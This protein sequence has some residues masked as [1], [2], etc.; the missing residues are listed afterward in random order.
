MPP[1]HHLRMRASR[2]LFWGLAVA[3]GLATA[4]AVTLVVVS[5]AGAGAL[6]WVLTGV[7]PLYA[8]A[9]FT[10]WRRPDHAAVRCLL[11]AAVGLAVSTLL[12]YWLHF[13]RPTSPPALWLLDTGYLVSEIAATVAGVGFFALFPV[14]RPERRYE[15]VIARTA[16][17]VAAALPVLLMTARPVLTV[18]P[19]SLPDFPAIVNPTYV[20]ALAPLGAVALGVYLGSWMA[21]LPLAGLLLVLRYRRSGPDQRRQIRWLLLA[22]GLAVLATVPWVTGLTWLGALLGAPC[23]VATVGCIVIA[24]LDAGLLDVDVLI[25]RSLVYATLWLL[26]ALGYVG[27]AAGL[28]LA[29]T[30]RLPVSVAVV[31][32][33]AAT[34]L[35]Q[36]ARRWLERLAERWVFGERISHYD[37]VTRFGDALEEVGTLDGLLPRLAE[38]IRHG[39][40]LRWARVRLDP[41][42]DRPR[43][44]MPEGRAGDIGDGPEVVPEV[45][46]PLVHHG[47]SVGVIECGPQRAGSFTGAD[48]R[49]LATLARQAAAV[50]HNLRLRAAQA[51]HLAEIGRRTAELTESRA[52]VVQVQDAERRR[53]QRQLHDGVQQS[54][55]ALSVRLGLARIQLR[56]GDDRASATTL[57]ELQGDVTHLLDQLRDLAHSIR[58][59]V[60]TDRGLLE[61]V[62]AQ[63]ARLPVPVVIRADRA[64][65]GR[66]FPQHIE[67]AAWYGIAE[68]MTNSLK[69]AA[70]GPIIVGLVCRDGRLAIDV[71]DDG[72]GFDVHAAAGFGLAALA[73]RMAVLG[74]RLTVDSAPGAGA[75]LR[76]ELPL[77]YLVERNG[78]CASPSQTT[79][80]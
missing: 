29:A 36:P 53:L 67:D 32:A 57:A 52:R 47:E 3:G 66:R 76:M 35:F 78:R 23:M 24:L 6:W 58:P 72:P 27:A 71:D 79:T 80:T 21:A 2:L 48:H 38:T 26:I 9:V 41:P 55:A 20:P 8:A 74:G 28:G 14:G 22:A 1:A 62:E 44:A 10:F 73:D 56:R 69:H 40:G 64:L 68:A 16:L 17:V 7:T 5:G 25:R 37:V 54:V 31:L 77:P 42:L 63:A 65:R 18:N 19:F 70:G 60:L 43:L 30:N 50:A 12:E 46:V 13:R 34:V 51:E 33:I 59:A 4:A 49:L 39:L 15:R 61:A 11:V 75:R 45:V